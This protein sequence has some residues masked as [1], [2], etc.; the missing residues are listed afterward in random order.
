MT[1]PGNSSRVMRK[2]VAR[3][4]FVEVKILTS[5]KHVENWGRS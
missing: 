4:E 2:V 5:K 3:N 1:D